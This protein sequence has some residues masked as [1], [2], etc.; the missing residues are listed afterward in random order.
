MGQ[1][2]TKTVR[3]IK[4][5]KVTILQ[6]WAIKMGE[7]LGPYGKIMP[8]P[9]ITPPPP[10]ESQPMDQDKHMVLAIFYFLWTRG[11][12]FDENWYD[13][14]FFRKKVMTPS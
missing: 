4:H 2:T 1:C 8:P 3:L 6:N 12:Q 10:P 5:F 7:K 13:Y 9:P 11:T 14:Q